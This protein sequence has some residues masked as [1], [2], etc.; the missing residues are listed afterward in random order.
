MWRNRSS[1]FVALALSCLITTLAT[2]SVLAADPP[3]NK[4]YFTI[5]VGMESPYS[6]GADCLRFSATELCTSDDVCGS[7]TFTEGPGPESGISFEIS[8]D[9]DQEILIDGQARIDDRG[10]KDSLA[11]VAQATVDGKSF[12]F[13]FTG[14]ST[15]RKKCGRL[16]DEWYAGDVSGEGAQP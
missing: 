10:K 13:S 5:F 3:I 7:W 1:V 6:W 12:N 9:G 15:N 8:D 14:R 2:E 4:T 11:G 16:V